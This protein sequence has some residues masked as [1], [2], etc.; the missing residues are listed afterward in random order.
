[1]IGA[2]DLAIY[3][4]GAAKAF[5]PVSNHNYHEMSSITEARYERFS[6]DIAE[7]VLDPS[8]E[9]LFAGV[10]GRVKTGLLLVSLASFESRFIGDVM[11]CK[12][13]GDNG[14]AAGPFQ[15]HQNKTKVCSSYKGA[16]LVAIS[17][18]RNSFHVC[19]NLTLDKQLSA[20]TDGNEWNTDEAFHRSEDRMDTA[21]RY[22]TGHKPVITYYNL[23]LN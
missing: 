15:S 12:K 13:L 8:T 9:P 4:L 11:S 14:L 3:L 17:M 23:G 18:V 10:D 22:Y 6:E 16:A 20:Y 2:H 21:I 19:H 7:L 1:M 5:Y